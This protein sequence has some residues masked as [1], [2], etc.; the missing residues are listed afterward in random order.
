MSLLASTAAAMASI[1]AGTGDLY[2]G[3]PLIRNGTL[4]TM[5]SHPI[6]TADCVHRPGFNGRVWN[7]RPING[8]GCDHPC[9]AWP[10]PGPAAYGAGGCDDAVV[11]GIVNH[12]LVTFSPWIKFHGETMKGYEQVRRQWLRENGY[13]G[14]VR[15]FVNDAPMPSDEAGAQSSLP[16]PRAIIELAPDAPRAKSRLR[17]DAAPKT[18]Q[19]KAAA[20]KPKVLAG[21]S[22]VVTVT[23]DRI[24]K[25]SSKSRMPIT[26]KVAGSSK[27]GGP[28]APRLAGR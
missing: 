14:G 13:T 21:G 19:P 26:G 17:V 20:I 16:E 4:A 1:A 22:G 24:P 15:T 9:H 2:L 25:A 28:S 10:A 12:T 23:N 18:N 7:A 8:P 3:Q 11:V 27:Q 5:R 6:N